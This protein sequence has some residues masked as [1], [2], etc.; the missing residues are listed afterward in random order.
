MSTLTP[1]FTPET[2]E[3]TDIG[4]GDD[5]EAR[6]IVFNC[7]CHTYQQVITLFCKVIPGMSSSRAF[8]LAWRIDH[9]GQATVYTGEKKAAEDIG[10]QLASG[11][12]RVSVH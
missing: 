7:D 8:E 5:L 9:E 3:T 4:T 10:K 1:V 12:L 2:E 6:V 11:G